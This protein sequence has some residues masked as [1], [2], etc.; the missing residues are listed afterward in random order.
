MLDDKPVNISERWICY[1]ALF[2]TVVRKSLVVKPNFS[3]IELK[4]V[5]PTED[6]VK[7][8]DCVF[9]LTLFRHYA[10]LQDAHF[11]IIVLDFSA[12]FV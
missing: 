4:L 1:F 2:S 7:D 8:C 9:I 5:K 3:V 11:I 6:V 10:V 12:D